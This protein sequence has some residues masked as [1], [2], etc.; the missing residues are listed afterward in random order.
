[1]SRAQTLLAAALR[2]EAGAAITIRAE[3]VPWH[4]A[5]L[6]GEQHRLLLIF[7]DEAAAERLLPGLASREW[8]LDGYVV[9][10][11]VAE[12]PRRAGGR[13]CVTV[14]ALTIAAD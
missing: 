13:L 8:T 1:M 7:E 11:I 3:T 4:S 6:S 5:R 9:A 2:A 12:P 10:D 14:E